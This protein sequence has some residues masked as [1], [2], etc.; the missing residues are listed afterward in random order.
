[1]IT[2]AFVGKLRQLAAQFPAV[3]ILGSRQCGKTTLA[4]EVIGGRYFD[5]ELNSDR[6]VFESDPELVLRRLAGS[7]IFD[8]AQIMPSLFPVLRALIDED[9]TAVGRFYLLGSVSPELVKGISESLAGRVGVLDLTPFLYQEV[10][11]TGPDALNA[12]WLRGGY[13]QAF[14]AADTVAWQ[15]MFENYF[16]TFIERDVTRSGLAFTP[17]EMRRF[18][19]MLAHLHGGLLNASDLGRS[20]GISYHT[21]QKAI[22]VLDAYF[23]VRQLMPYHANIGKRLVKAPKVFL[24]DSGLLHYLLGI[25]SDE[26]LLSSPARGRSWEGFVIE[27]VMAAEE[28]RRRGSQFHFYRTQTG[29]EIDLIIDRGQERIGVEIKC[30]ASVSA[31]D[32]VNLR[33]GLADGIIHRG[34]VVYPGTRAFPVTETITVLPA[35]EVVG[36]EDFTTDLH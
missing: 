2:R 27:Q 22:D 21:V 19:T 11:A 1:M 9:R 33:Q 28:L 18:M 34:V 30:A 29:V 13:P 25:S 23:L 3:L 15:Y 20:M 14:L 16:R 36:L 17:Q 7:I 5:L 12:L 10:R 24:R 8:E 31:S 35:T 26:G 32:T 6:Q 4:K